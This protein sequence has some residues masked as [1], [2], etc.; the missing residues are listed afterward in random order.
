MEFTGAYR[1]PDLSDH[2]DDYDDDHHLER[3]SE[4]YLRHPFFPLKAVRPSGI[5]RPFCCETLFRFPHESTRTMNIVTAADALRCR[6]ITSTHDPSIHP[7]GSPLRSLKL[8]KKGRRRD[9]RGVIR[10]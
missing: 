3:A 1:H 9:R 8:I 2:D 6:Y 4:R 5:C 7:S 10:G